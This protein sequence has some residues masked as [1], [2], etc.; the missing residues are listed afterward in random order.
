[1]GLARVYSVTL[2]TVES[3]NPKMQPPFTSI[4]VGSSYYTKAS[5]IK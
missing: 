2:R 5:K 1:M 4:T 3:P